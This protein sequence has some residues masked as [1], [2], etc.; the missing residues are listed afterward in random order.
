MVEHSDSNIQ[1]VV[2]VLADLEKELDT[3]KESIEDMKRELITLARNAAEA[4][5][6]DLVRKANDSAQKSVMNSKKA[7]EKEAAKILTRANLDMKLLN[8]K[9]SKT[10]NQAVDLVLKTMMGEKA[11]S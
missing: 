3:T 1:R 5:R 4:A 8:G 6:D 9:I 7:A 11:A 10:F 2:S